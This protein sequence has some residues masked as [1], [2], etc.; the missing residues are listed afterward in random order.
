MEKYNKAWEVAS[1]KVF[2]QVQKAHEDQKALKREIQF[3][4]GASSN[5]FLNKAKMNQMADKAL[6]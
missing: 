4:K 2:D 5:A 3:L 1:K 6:G